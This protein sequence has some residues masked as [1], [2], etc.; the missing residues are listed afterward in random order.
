MKTILLIAT[1]LIAGCNQVP[2]QMV[3]SHRNHGDDMDN[4]GNIPQPN[5]NE[6][7]KPIIVVAVKK[8]EP[9][10]ADGWGGGY[11]SIIVKDKSGEY[12]NFNGAY[13]VG[14]ALIATYN[15]GDRS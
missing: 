12:F 11:G 9:N 10:A 15:I 7:I 14:E 4:S 6:L 8:R 13:L 2:R 1:I 5:M 3:A